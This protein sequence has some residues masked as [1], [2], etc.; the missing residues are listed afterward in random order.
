SSGDVE[1]GRRVDARGYRLVY[2]SSAVVEHP[3]RNTVAELWKRTR[4]VAGGRFDL[5]HLAPARAH[6]PP[7][8]R[9]TRALRRLWRSRHR[10]GLARCLAAAALGLGLRFCEILFR[11]QFLAGMPRPRS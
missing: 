7:L 10:F 11:F 1:W 3:T 9:Y 2:A 5:R 4:R 6:V 8:S